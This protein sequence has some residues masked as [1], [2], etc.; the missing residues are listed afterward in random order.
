MEFLAAVGRIFNNALPW[1]SAGLGLLSTVK[2]F[3]AAGNI[4][5]QGRINRGILELEAVYAWR[6]QEDK[7]NEERYQQNLFYG[8]QVSAYGKSGVFME[9]TPMGVL[10]D[11]VDR[12]EQDNLARLHGAE[13]EQSKLAA[14]AAKV[15]FVAYQQGSSTRAEA[16]GNLGATLLTSNLRYPLTWDETERKAIT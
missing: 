4:E 1:V 12:F 11:I 15:E 13:S 9:G 16:L 8:A 6:A 3:G 5:K 2:Q 10:S 14:E 7:A